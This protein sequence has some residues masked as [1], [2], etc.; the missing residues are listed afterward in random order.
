MDYKKGDKFKVLDKNK[1]SGNHRF[2]NGGLYTVKE[3]TD[4]GNIYVENQDN[5]N[6]TYI[7]SNERSA[8]ELVDC[9][10]LETV[11]EKYKA[12][13]KIRILNKTKINQ[14]HSFV[15]G[16]VLVIGEVVANGAIF[17]VD[18]GP[19]NLPHIG[20]YEYSAIEK[21]VEQDPTINPCAE[22][23]DIINEPRFNTLSHIIEALAQGK[24]I[25]G[26]G[27]H[28][29]EDK[30]IHMKD[31]KL[32]FYDGDRYGGS[33]KEPC[34][35]KLYKEP[36]KVIM[37]NVADIDFKFVASEIVRGMTPSCLSKKQIERL[38]HVALTVM[39]NKIVHH[40][41]GE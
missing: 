34:N 29:A 2:W 5:R 30:Y 18:K 4:A 11:E 7:M 23:L 37:V 25:C 17:V 20:N 14:G 36:K 1:I 22:L 24:K 28:W 40:K 13:D 35:W 6:L 3:V 38:E 21:V 10:P 33:F 8:I 41:G 32:T 15:D 19:R 39:A 27:V 12:G 26:T 31:G 9:K 16:E